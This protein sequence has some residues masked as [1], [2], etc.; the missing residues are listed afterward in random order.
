MGALAEVMAKAL[1]RKLEIQRERADSPKIGLYLDDL[2]YLACKADPDV[3]SMLGYSAAGDRS[4]M[5]IGGM[6]VFVVR[7][8]RLHLNVAVIPD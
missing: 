8:S 2:T 1:R 6:Q 3:L 4:P 7:T 5:T